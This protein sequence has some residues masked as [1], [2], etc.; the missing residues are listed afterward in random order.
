[1]PHP[2][3]DDELLAFLTAGFARTGKLATVRADGR[4]HVAPIWFVLDPTTATVD[5]PL[6]DVVFN[7]DAA[8]VKGKSLQRDPR[9]ALCVDD[10]RPPFSFV[11]IEGEAT[12]SDDLAE[13]VRWATVIGGRYMGEEQA[14]AYGE[15][16]GAP[17]ELLVRVRPIHVVAVADL[18][19]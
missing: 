1:M 5:S 2:M 3:S 18:A 6:G 9:V 8:S 11:S 16:N 12:I 17:G 10:E 13:V 4:P 19:D 7:T 15:R 14:E